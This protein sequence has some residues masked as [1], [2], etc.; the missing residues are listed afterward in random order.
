M[1]NRIRVEKVTMAWPE[2]SEDEEVETLLTVYEAEYNVTF[3]YFAAP[4]GFYT[5][6]VGGEVGQKPF[7]VW[8]AK[9]PDGPWGGLEPDVSAVDILESLL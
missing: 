2:K 7:I 9:T 5:G 3:V 8:E 6:Y 4:W 1:K